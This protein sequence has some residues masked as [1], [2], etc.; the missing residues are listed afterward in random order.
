MNDLESKN[1]CGNLSVDDDGW[2]GL[3]S[4]LSTPTMEIEDVIRKKISCQINPELLPE[5]HQQMVDLIYSFRDLLPANPKR[6]PLT[7]LIKHRIENFAVVYT[8]P[9]R[10]S[11][12]EY[13]KQTRLCRRWK[14][15]EL[16]DLPQAHTIL[17]L[18]W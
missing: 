11:R 12:S 16:S 17:P 3:V 9:F 18:S 10:L 4:K 15:M 14:K 13:E 6:P 2:I 7:P 8:K 1:L 5:Q